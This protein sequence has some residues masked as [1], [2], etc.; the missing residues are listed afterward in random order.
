METLDSSLTP[1][2]HSHIYWNHIQAFQLP[3][4]KYAAWVLF[5]VTEGRFRYE[6]G[7]QSGEAGFGD[8]VLCPPDTRFAREVIEPLSFHFYR[9]DWIA[10]NERNGAL[11]TAVRL[12]VRDHNR[13]ASNY[14]YL[15]H[16]S[17]SSNGDMARHDLARHLLRDLWQLSCIE[18]QNASDSSRHRPPK[19]NDEEDM[20]EAARMIRHH[21][22]GR[23]IMKELAESIG[24]SPVRFTRKFQSAF[25]QTPID[26]LTTLR[27]RKAQA[28]LLE[29]ELTLDQ[30]AER[31]G[32]DNGFYLS[33][34]FS[35]RLHISPAAYRRTNRI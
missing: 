24:L 23:L 29:S 12:T 21:A 7:G 26:Y 3:E 25:G 4:D 32:Y 19:G 17:A 18:A 35:K 10:D 14:Y 1:L 6:I 20:Q 28:M 33:R 27:L 31:C 22:Y 34:V 15:K 9:F 16:L 30:I 11:P 8:L 2:A 13:L 5:A